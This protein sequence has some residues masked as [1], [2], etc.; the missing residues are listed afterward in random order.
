MNELDCVKLIKPYKDLKVE[1]RGCIVLKYTKNDFEVEFFDEN[2]E[3]ID[4]YT[5]SREY[6]EVYWTP[7]KGY[8][9]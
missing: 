6:L 8:I 3:T 2:N 1:T 7:E 5:I 4:V 9:K